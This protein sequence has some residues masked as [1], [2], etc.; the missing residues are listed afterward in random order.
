MKTLNLHLFKVAILHLLCPLCLGKGFCV[1]SCESSDL[2]RKWFAKDFSYEIFCYLSHG[3]EFA[4]VG[5]FW[6]FFL[7]EKLVIVTN[8]AIWKELHHRL[9]GRW[10]LQ[11]MSVFRGGKW[12]CKLK[13]IYSGRN[14]QFINWSLL[15]LLFVKVFYILPCRV[16]I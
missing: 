10:S 9:S 11:I 8:T 15:Q 5:G 7:P 12:K 13:I 16:F 1:V 4:F 6:V 2:G 3:L 14:I